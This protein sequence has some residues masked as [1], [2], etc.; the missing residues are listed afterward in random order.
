M[1]EF[2]ELLKQCRSIPVKFDK[3]DNHIEIINIRECKKHS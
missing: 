1:I 2:N 3:C